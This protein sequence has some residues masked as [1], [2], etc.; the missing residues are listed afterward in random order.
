MIIELWKITGTCLLKKVSDLTEKYIPV[1]SISSSHNAPW[2]TSNLKRLSNKKKRMYRSAKL[3]GNDA[4]WAAYKLANDNY[5]AALRSAKENFF[6]TILPTVL[7][8]DNKKFWRT[9]NPRDNN[10]VRLTDTDGAAIPPEECA[11]TF[12]ETFVRNF[13]FSENVCLPPLETF[14]YIDMFPIIIE[15]SGVAKLIKTLKVSSAPGC[16][17]SP[18]FLHST[19]AYSSIILTKIFQQSLDDGCL[20]ADWT[21]GKVIPI[22]KSGNKNSPL[23]YRPIS[24]TSISC[25]I[26]EHVR[27]SHVVNFLQSNSFFT[28]SQHGFRKSYSCE[29]QLV[30]FTHKL[31]AIL[32]RSSSADC[33][34]LGFSK[35]F[36]KVCHKLLLHKLRQLNIEPKLLAWLEIFLTYSLVVCFD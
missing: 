25:K 9:I 22:H 35:A 2:Y 20:P 23:N 29:T 17:I 7:V 13:S 10:I 34:C 19:C 16:D 24:L 27:F 28:R 32:D 33:I 8:T 12:N 21:V 3:S 4:R 14:N 30:S 1:H 5:V 18:K 11:K 36:D 15:A 6:R 31:H 26:L